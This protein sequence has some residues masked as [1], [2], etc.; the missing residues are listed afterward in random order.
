MSIVKSSNCAVSLQLPK[1]TFT[2]ICV[3][4]Y[5]IHIHTRACNFALMKDTAVTCRTLYQQ[6]FNLKQCLKWYKLVVKYCYIYSLNIS[7]SSLGKG[8]IVSYYRSYYHGV[9]TVAFKVHDMRFC[10]L[11]TS[12]R[13]TLTIT[14]QFTHVKP[15]E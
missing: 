12:Q 10:G 14:R 8:L 5:N 1:D 9:I 15:Q 13:S 3:T 11:A 2:R 7:L 6:C 4:L